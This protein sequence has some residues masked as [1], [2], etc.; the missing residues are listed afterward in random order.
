MRKTFFLI[1]FLF[2]LSVNAAFSQTDLPSP[3]TGQSYPSGTI[4]QAVCK[5][6]LAHEES[7]WTDFQWWDEKRGGWNSFTP[8]NSAR[9]LSR[10]IQYARK[11]SNGGKCRTLGS[12]RTQL[13]CS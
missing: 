4:L 11:I 2:V 8:G 3:K 1:Y 7:T 12:R 5:P 10:T 13:D 6:A 9:H